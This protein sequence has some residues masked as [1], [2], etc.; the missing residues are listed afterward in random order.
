MWFPYRSASGIRVLVRFPSG[1]LHSCAN[2]HD[3]ARASDAY[4]YGRT[5]ESTVTARIGDTARIGGVVFRA[6][7]ARGGKA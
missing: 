5:P 6:V 1:L 4:S 2:E 7:N 3:A